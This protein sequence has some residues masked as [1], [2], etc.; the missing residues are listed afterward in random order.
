MPSR[1]RKKRDREINVG[2]RVYFT[3]GSRRVCGTVV[4]DRGNIGARGRRLYSIRADLDREE[5][6]IIELPEE[7][8]KRRRPAA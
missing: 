3:V 2:D 4:E 1:S 6:S 8:L 7:E 5:E